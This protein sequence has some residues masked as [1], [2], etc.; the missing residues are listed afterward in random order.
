MPR[1]WRRHAPHPAALLLRSELHR[2]RPA[3][4]DERYR[5]RSGL[6]RL[7]RKRGVEHPQLGSERDQL[8]VGGRVVVHAHV[9]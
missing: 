4:R 1:R 8:Y 9:G 2:F 7:Y 6:C 5:H 3:Q